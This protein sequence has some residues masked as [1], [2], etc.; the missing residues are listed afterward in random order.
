MQRS[1]I[2]FVRGALGTKF[3]E[4]SIINCC[5]ILANTFVLF[6][7]EN[8]CIG[9]VLLV[10]NGLKPRLSE[11]SFTNYDGHIWI[12]LNES[13]P[14]FPLIFGN[15]LTELILIRLILR[16]GKTLFS[17]QVPEFWSFTINTLFASIEGMTLRA[18]TSLSFRIVDIALNTVHH[19]FEASLSWF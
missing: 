6:F 9:A 18:N 12:W 17:I 1:Y 14:T 10:N 13:R 7:I 5:F 11:I 2:L 15:T 8:V 3:T 19:E 4:S 16:A